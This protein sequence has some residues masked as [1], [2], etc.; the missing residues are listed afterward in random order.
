MSKANYY[1]KLM[2]ICKQ[3]T[4]MA[5]PGTIIGQIQAAPTPATLQQVTANQAQLQQLQTAAGQPTLTISAAAPQ[6][7]PLPASVP[8]ITNKD[9]V[10]DNSGGNSDNVTQSTVTIEVPKENGIN[11]GKLIY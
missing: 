3:L 4:Q 5:P 6:Q 2:N 10:I 7:V 9:E 11:E 8:P 1:E